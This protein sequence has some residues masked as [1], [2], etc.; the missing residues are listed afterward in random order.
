MT[1]SRNYVLC[2]IRIIRDQDFFLILI[3]WNQLIYQKPQR[4]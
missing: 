3:R 1:K 4:R 2:L